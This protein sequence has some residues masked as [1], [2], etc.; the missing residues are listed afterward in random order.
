M[1]TITRYN[2]KK[3][4]RHL[5]VQYYGERPVERRFWSLFNFVLLTNNKTKQIVYIVNV[6]I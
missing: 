5:L 4:R 1:Y 3:I 2:V 6:I